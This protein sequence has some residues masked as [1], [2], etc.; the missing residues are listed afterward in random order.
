MRASW[1]ARS[2]ACGLAVAAGVVMQAGIASAGPPGPPAFGVMEPA[3]N[4]CPWPDFLND[5]MQNVQGVQKC[6][7][8]SIAWASA[9]GGVRIVSDAL[10]ATGDIPG[11]TG[12]VTFW[13][14][15]KVGLHF[16]VTVQGLAPAAT[17]SVTGHVMGSSTVL[18][19]GTVRTDRSGNGIIGGVIALPPGEYDVH[20]F[21]G[22]VLEPASSDP[23]VEFVVF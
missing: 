13:C 3:S 8:A 18:D 1:L 14:Q 10:E 16:I 20:V 15:S 6:L 7:P 22:N 4:A 12:Q 21:V 11:A 19:F 2:V 17:Y 5:Y 9:E 23:D